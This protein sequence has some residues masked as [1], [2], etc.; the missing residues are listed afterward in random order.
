MRISYEPK[1]VK[2]LPPHLKPNQKLIG[3]LENLLGKVEAP[4]EASATRIAISPA[5]IRKTMGRDLV[6]LKLQN[7]NATEKQLFKLILISRIDARRNKLKM[8]LTLENS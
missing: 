2:L 5:F 3:E 4:H 1:W 7:P 8:V 6:Y